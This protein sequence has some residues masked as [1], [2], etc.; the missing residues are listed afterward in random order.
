VNFKKRGDSQSKKY[1]KTKSI[2]YL[3]FI[4]KA[5]IFNTILNTK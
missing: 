3:Y 4:R 5:K 1:Y 2:I